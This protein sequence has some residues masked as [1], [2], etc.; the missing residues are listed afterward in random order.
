MAEP[1]ANPFYV[2]GVTGALLFK[3]PPGK[4]VPREINGP[5]DL[6]GIPPTE[7]RFGVAFTSVFTSTDGQ[8]TRLVVF[9]EQVTPAAVPP[10]VTC[11]FI[12]YRDGEYQDGQHIGG[13]PTAEVDL[14]PSESIPGEFI[15][16]A[17]S[18]WLHRVIHVEQYDYLRY[19]AVECRVTQV[20]WP[21]QFARTKSDKQNKKRQTNPTQAPPVYNP[22]FKTNHP[23]WP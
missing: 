11:A 21:N 19:Y 1:T 12:H 13:D 23:S 22:D 7:P 3:L 18:P 16:R 9:A 6:P 5:D 15:Y 2:P 8:L 10:P 14:L 4:D 17:Q 20:T